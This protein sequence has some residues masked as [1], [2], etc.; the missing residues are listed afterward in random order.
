M[1]PPTAYTEKDAFWYLHL[2]P[3][4]QAALDLFTTH[5]KTKAL[6]LKGH[7]DKY[8]LLR[9]LK[10]RQWD[11]AK[12]T[13]M[14]H[15]MVKWRHDHKVDD[16]YSCFEYPELLEVFPVY[17]HFYHKQ[18]KFGR[19]VYIELLG[20][21]DCTKILQHTTL[22][23]LLDYH[24]FTWERFERLLLPVCTQIVGKPMATTC[25]IIDLSG[26]SLKNF[27]WAA[28][29]LLTTVAKIDQDYYPEHLGQMFIINTP[30]IF[31]TIWA[32]VYPLLE[33]RTRKKIHV[34][35]HDY[36][37]TL[38]DVIPEDNLLVEYGGR[39]VH[40]DPV[41]SIGAWCEVEEM[42]A[43]SWLPLPRKEGSTQALPGGEAAA[44]T[45][46]VVS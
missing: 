11:T 20:K 29:R 5:L 28:Q 10:A 34:L 16:M 14:Y 27:T 26:L 33:E 4:Q 13:V 3:E 36:Q 30:F 44:A 35:G 40:P 2:T 6:L 43:S 25:V 17:P 46:G 21:T 31:K 38:R 32:V 37:R 9:F 12:A 24:I 41:S 45:V 18:D 39:S 42:K 15:D 8:T 22:E 19:P 23:R 1:P 7:D